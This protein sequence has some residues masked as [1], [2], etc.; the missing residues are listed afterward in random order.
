MAIITNNDTKVTLVLKYAEARCLRNALLSRN[1]HARWGSYVKCTYCLG[2]SV[3]DDWRG[4]K[5]TS[6]CIVPMLTALPIGEDP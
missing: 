6:T 2:E 3:D 4:V 5:H 1:W